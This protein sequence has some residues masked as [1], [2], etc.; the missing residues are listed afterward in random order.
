MCKVFVFGKKYNTG[1][2]TLI[3]TGPCS[4]LQ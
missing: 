1:N 4:S 2:G 3:C